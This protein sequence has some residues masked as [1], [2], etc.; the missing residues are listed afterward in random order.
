MEGVEGESFELRVSGFELRLSAKRVGR[1]RQEAASGGVE[2]EVLGS[3][4]G[5]RNL[6]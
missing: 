4:L 5:M 3:E 6:E 1:L 2:G